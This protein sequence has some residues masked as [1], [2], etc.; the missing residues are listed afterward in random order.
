MESERLQLLRAFLNKRNF[1]IWTVKEILS[2]VH[3]L[4]ENKDD[5]V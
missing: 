4:Y 2:F 1:S 3:F 5:V